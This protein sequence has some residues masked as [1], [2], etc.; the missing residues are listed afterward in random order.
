MIL[1]VEKELPTL[2]KLD[3]SG[4]PL[5]FKSLVAIAVENRADIY[6]LNKDSTDLLEQIQ[7]DIVQS[8]LASVN[9][10]ITYLDIKQRAKSQK[11]ASDG[12]NVE[13]ALSQQS[14]PILSTVTSLPIKLDS[15]PLNQNV[16]MARITKALNEKM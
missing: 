14:T 7:L 10:S 3:L 8:R 1:H 6:Q 2:K 5:S 16:A 4:N 11:Q 9:S 13:Q 15:T 12:T